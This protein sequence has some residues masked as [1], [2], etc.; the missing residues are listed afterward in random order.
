MESLS[1]I[2]H[3]GI[4]MGMR[5]RY[6]ADTTQL[7][8]CGDGIIIQKANAVPEH[9]ALLRLN[10]QCPLGDSKGRFSTNA[11]ETW[12]ELPQRVVKAILICSAYRRNWRLS[13]QIGH[14]CGGVWLC[15]N[16]LPHEA[17]IQ[18]SI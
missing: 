2:H 8:D 5:D 3:R 6:R 7:L 10:Q 13:R 9:I 14:P 17:Q 12:F 15:A 4:K 16:W 1:P 11:Y 18:F